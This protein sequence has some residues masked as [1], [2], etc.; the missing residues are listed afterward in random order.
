MLFQMTNQFN[1]ERVSSFR[2]D[3]NRIFFGSNKAKNY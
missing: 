2:A 3:M 1:L